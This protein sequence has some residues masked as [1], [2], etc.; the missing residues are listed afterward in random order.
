MKKK[1]SDVV[2]DITEVPLNP[3][4]KDIFVDL[5]GIIW[6]PHFLVQDGERVLE[7]PAFKAE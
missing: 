3:M 5:Y 6:L 4:K 2:D 7:V 1:W